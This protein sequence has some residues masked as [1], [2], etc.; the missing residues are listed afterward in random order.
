MLAERRQLELRAGVHL[1][2]LSA[3]SVITPITVQ[4]VSAE[5]L[6]NFLTPPY[7]LLL[8]ESQYFHCT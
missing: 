7:T 5:P 1:L 4:S 3:C 6:L 2:E 8:H